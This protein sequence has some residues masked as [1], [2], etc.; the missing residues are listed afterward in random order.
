[1]HRY[2]YKEAETK[3]IKSNRKKGSNVDFN[4]K[5]LRFI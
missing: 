1:M 3:E 4:K 2:F 5:V